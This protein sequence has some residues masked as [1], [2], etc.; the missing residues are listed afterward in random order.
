LIVAALPLE[1]AEHFKTVVSAKAVEPARTRAATI[2]FF[3][4]VSLVV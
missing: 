4:D 3:M 2:S 1:G